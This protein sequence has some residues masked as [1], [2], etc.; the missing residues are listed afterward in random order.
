MKRKAK[1]PKVHIELTCLWGNGDVSSTIKVS[2][3]RWKQ[4]QDGAEY[5]TSASSWYEG[6]RYSVVWSF[7]DAKVPVTAGDGDGAE[8]AIEVPVVELMSE[9]VTTG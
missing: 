9:T 1:K 4:I 7:S 8:Y 6:K 5:E 3:R 2:R